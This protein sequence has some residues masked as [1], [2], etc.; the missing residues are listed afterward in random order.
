MI[1][2]LILTV[3][4][5]SRAAIA[6]TGDW[7][8]GDWIDNYPGFP[9]IKERRMLVLVNA[10][11]CAPRQYRDACLV[12]YN[13]GAGDILTQQYYPSVPQ[14][15]WHIDLNRAARAHSIDM[16]DNIGLSHN[17]SDGTSAGDRIRTYYENAG[18]WGENVASGN[19]DA[20]STMRQWLLDITDYGT[21]R[22]AADN[23]GSD[24]HRKNIMNA[25]YGE[26]G[27]GYAYGS[28]QYRHF[29]TLD[30]ARAGTQYT[31]PITGGCHFLR[32]DSIL[33]MAGFMDTLS[34]GPDSS[35]VYIQGQKYEMHCKFGSR[36]NGVYVRRLPAA[37]MCREYFFSFADSQSG[38]TRYPA[39]GNLKTKG[40]GQCDSGY[41]PEPSPAIAAFD[42][43][44]AGCAT[45]DMLF[46]RTSE[47]QWKLT[48]PRH[49]YDARRLVVIDCN[50][51]VRYSRNID[52]KPQQ[53]RIE[54][55]GA[56]GF[57]LVGLYNR[58]EHFSILGRILLMQ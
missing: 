27:A 38:H 29:W 21:Q 2:I 54:L 23:S 25:S 33:F 18:G 49:A 45:I 17:S 4:Y 9:S 57:F 12:P 46:Q 41:T 44:V 7:G 8:Y 36:A 51:A 37:S 28:K 58:D 34:D 31:T 22:P 14:V 52:T 20:A 47:L 40:E 5:L 30:C 3:I 13:P 39:H 16:A 26:M 10:C 55:P 50:G 48:L 15:Y 35:L 42:S 1:R 6:D 53:L 56:Q 43:P 32:N 24:G 11:R 19:E